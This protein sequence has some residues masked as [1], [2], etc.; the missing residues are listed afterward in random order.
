MIVAC[1]WPALADQVIPRVRPVGSRITA[2]LERGYAASHTLAVLVDALEDT[3]II[4]HVTECWVLEG[5]H[6][7]DTQF[8]TTAGGQRYL[9]IRLDMRLHDEAA[10]AMLGHELQHAWEIAAHPWVADQETLGQL[11]AQIGY[12]SQRALGS[13]A[14]ETAAARDTARD[15]L[16]ELKA[17][18]RLL[19]STY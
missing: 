17:G 6:A 5:A 16:K 8:V 13:H 15:V 18:Q 3:D 12:E 1:T 19:T 7:G 10:I 9:R 4:V 2:L 11:Y 14:G